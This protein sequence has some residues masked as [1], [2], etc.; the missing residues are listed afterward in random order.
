MPKRTAISSENSGKGL[1]TTYDV[2]WHCCRR[3]HMAKLKAKMWVES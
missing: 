3:F 2:R 1:Q